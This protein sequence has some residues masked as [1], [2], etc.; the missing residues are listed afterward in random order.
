MGGPSSSGP[1][2]S[3]YDLLIQRLDLRLV[4]EV[5]I[6]RRKRIGAGWLGPWCPVIHVSLVAYLQPQ[7]GGPR[8]PARTTSM[9]HRCCPGDT[10]KTHLT[11]EHLHETP[12][13]PCPALAMCA[14]GVSAAKYREASLVFRLPEG[15]REMGFYFKIAPGVKI[16]AT[17]RGLRPSVGP[18]AARVHFGAGGTGVSTGAGPVSLPGY[19]RRVITWRGYAS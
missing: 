18:R 14:A 3:L 15:R 11:L 7:P 4:D 19:V 1:A 16:R 9:E 6:H 2:V 10:Q 17:R 13:A 8:G 12:D 5:R